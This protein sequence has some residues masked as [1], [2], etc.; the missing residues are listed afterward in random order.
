LIGYIDKYGFF[1][2]DLKVEGV[3]LESSSIEENIGFFDK[4][5]FE[6]TFKTW[7]ENAKLTFAIMQRI[8]SHMNFGACLQKKRKSQILENVVRTYNS[9]SEFEAYLRRASFNCLNNPVISNI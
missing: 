4:L 9:S 3:E 1:M 5:L 6:N 8:F 7:L 2:I